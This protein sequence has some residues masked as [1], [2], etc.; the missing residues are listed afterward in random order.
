MIDFIAVCVAQICAGYVF[1]GC[2][3]ELWR[4]HKENKEVQE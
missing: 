4:M 3:R 1:I 2:A